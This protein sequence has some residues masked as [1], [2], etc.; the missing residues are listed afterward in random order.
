M[1]KGKGQE[2]KEDPARL[3]KANQQGLD[4]NMVN[5]RETYSYRQQ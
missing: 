4:P 3:E 5:I 2:R 1:N